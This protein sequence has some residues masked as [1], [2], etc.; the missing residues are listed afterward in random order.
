MNPSPDLCLLFETH[1]TTLDNEAGLASGHFDVELSATGEDQARA[2]GERRQHDALSAVFCSDLRRACRTAEIAFAHRALPIVRDARLRECDYGTLTHRP[3]QEIEAQRAAH[4]TTPFPKGESYEQ[5]TSRVAAWLDEATSAYARQ[6][7]LVV[8]VSLLQ[9][10]A[11]S[12]FSST[13]PPDTY[14]LCQGR[15]TWPDELM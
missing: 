15:R 2:L 7:V 6:T 11:N 14:S 13:R 9:N 3:V 1:A 10:S 8:L 12:D 5:V 4:L